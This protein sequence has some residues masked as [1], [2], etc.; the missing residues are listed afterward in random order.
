MSKKTRISL[1]M[2]GGLLAALSLILLIAS[3]GT[4]PKQRAKDSMRLEPTVFQ[5]P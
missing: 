5:K 2:V 4:Q 1:S 3:A